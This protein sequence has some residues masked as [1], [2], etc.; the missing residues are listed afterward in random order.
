MLTF[1]TYAGE[2]GTTLNGVHGQMRPCTELMTQ[3]PRLK[4]NVTLQGHGMYS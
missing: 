3:L 4:V 2:S 1:W